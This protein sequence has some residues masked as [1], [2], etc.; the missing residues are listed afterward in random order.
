MYTL[1]TGER[2]FTHEF[3]PRLAMMISRGS[4][5]HVKLENA[6][7]VLEHGGHDA[8]QLIE[9]CLELDPGQRME[10]A[11]ALDSEWL[12]GVRALYEESE[13]A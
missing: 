13:F 3:V 1:L 7:A 4:Y 11:Q 12:Y 8:I 2:P 5:D 6:P 10:I 9:G